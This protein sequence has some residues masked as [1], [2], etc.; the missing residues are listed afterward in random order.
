MIIY[1][2]NSF[3]ILDYKAFTG[4]QLASEYLDKINKERMFSSTLFEIELVTDQFME[5]TLQPHKPRHKFNKDF[6]WA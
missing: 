5:L 3:T 6:L 2:I 4:K 1:L